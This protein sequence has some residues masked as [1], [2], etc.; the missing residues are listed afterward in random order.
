MSQHD[1]IKRWLSLGRKL[2]PLQALELFGC[3]RLAARIWDLRA[4][5]MDIQV[6][7]KEL[8]NGKVVA[9]YYL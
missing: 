2:T 8:P 5:G 4:S 9:E 1:E 3:L 6:R 7:K